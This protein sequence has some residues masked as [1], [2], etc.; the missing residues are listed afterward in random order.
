MVPTPAHNPEAWSSGP[1]PVLPP[2]HASSPSSKS[3]GCKNRQEPSIETQQAENQLQKTGREGKGMQA[4]PED[5]ETRPCRQRGRRKTGL[6]G[7]RKE[8]VQRSTP[9]GEQTASPCPRPGQGPCRPRRA[10]RW[11]LWH[12]PGGSKLTPHR[13]FPQRRSKL[14]R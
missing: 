12:Y 14:R 10:A 4:A 11:R 7:C 1:S 3:S 13:H 5:P 8:E 2:F 9:G 6:G